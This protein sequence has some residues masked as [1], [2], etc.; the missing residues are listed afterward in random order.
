MAAASCG[1]GQEG[2]TSAQPEDY[3]VEVL[4]PVTPVPTAS[5]DDQRRFCRAAIAA[6]NGR[7]PSIIRV[8]SDDGGIVRVRYARD[9]DKVWT[10][11]C[12]MVGSNVEWR[13]VDNGM[14]GRWRTEETIIPS[15]E[16][17]K[18]RVIL[19]IEGQIVGEQTYA[20]R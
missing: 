8:V 14:P 5:K 10:N 16:G 11:E 17:D 12:R 18:V 1:K 2:Q 20:V 4:E 7:D 13:M 19:A 9:D 6:L 15:I 3:S